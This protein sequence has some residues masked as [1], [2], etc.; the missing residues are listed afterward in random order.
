MS[1]RD[2]YDAAQARIYTGQWT[3]NVCTGE[4]V[5]RNGRKLGSLTGTGYVS[6]GVKM[7]GKVRHVLAHR[8]VWEHIHGPMDPEMTLDHLDANKANNS[9]RNLELVTREENGR[10][11]ALRW[12]RTRAAA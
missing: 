6:L 8:V 9:L 7:H 1:A 11:A 12:L 3:V 10:R 4:I 5:A 2:T